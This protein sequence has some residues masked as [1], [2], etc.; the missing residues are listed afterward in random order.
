MGVV[1][2][3]ANSFMVVIVKGGISAIT[4]TSLEVV[5]KLVLGLITNNS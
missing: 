5:P 2:V 1:K 3:T 4:L